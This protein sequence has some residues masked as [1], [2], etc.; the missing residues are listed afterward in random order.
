MKCVT[1]RLNLVRNL[2]RFV[3]IVERYPYRISLRSGNHVRD[4][5]SILGILSLDL[6]QPLTL[7]IDHDDCEKLLDELNP[8]IEAAGA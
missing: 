3:S 7:E 5:R 8:F 4:A 1:V 6:S 2:N